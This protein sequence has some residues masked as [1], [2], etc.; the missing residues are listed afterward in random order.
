M[1]LSGKSTRYVQISDEGN[2]ANFEFCPNCDA[3]GYYTSEDSEEMI[4]I[5]VGVFA[6]SI[7]PTPELGDLAASAFDSKR[8]LPLRLN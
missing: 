7:F 8:T 3:T 6:E 5:P 4:A 2:K 1:E